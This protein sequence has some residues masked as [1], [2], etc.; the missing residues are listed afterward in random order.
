MPYGLK[1]KLNKKGEMIKM[2]RCKYCKS[3]DFLTIDHKVS[4]IHGGTDEIKNLQCL[5]VRCNTIKSGLDDGQVRRF[6]NWFLQV[7]E[8]RKNH[9]SNPYKIR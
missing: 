9:G 2:K 1:Q 7:Q 6:F 4:K 5:C 3:P 8:S